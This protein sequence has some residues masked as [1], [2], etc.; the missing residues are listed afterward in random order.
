MPY[1]HQFKLP[2]PTQVSTADL[3]HVREGQM[4]DVAITTFDPQKI[5][6]LPATS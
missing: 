1:A 5:G 6:Q 2:P 3:D 4:V